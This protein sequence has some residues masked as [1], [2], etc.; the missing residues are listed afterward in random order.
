MSQRN[1]YSHCKTPEELQK[2]YPNMYID[3]EK[4]RKAINNTNTSLCGENHYVFKDKNNCVVGCAKCDEDE[5]QENSPYADM[6]S[7]D[8]TTWKSAQ[9]DA[10]ISGV[11]NN[12]WKNIM[13]VLHTKNK[14]ST[15]EKKNALNMAKQWY[16]NRMDD[17]E[18]INRMNA[19]QWSP[20]GEPKLSENKNLSEVEKE[21]KLK[22]YLK[23][24]KK[25]ISSGRGSTISCVEPNENGEIEVNKDTKLEL[26]ENWSTIKKNIIGPKGDNQLRWDGCDVNKT[27]GPKNI[28]QEEYL[29]WSEEYL[30]NQRSKSNILKDS[31]GAIISDLNA[32]G[33]VT[34]NIMG[35]ELFPISRPFENCINQLLSDYEYG[36]EVDSQMITDIN[37]KNNITELDEKHIEFI[38]RKL[39]LLLISNSRIGV[40]QCMI[41][42]ILK[43]KN[44]CPKNLPQQMMLILNIL[45]S[46]IG[47]NLHLNKLQDNDKQGR[48]KLISIIDKLGD[49]IPRAISKIIDITEEIER[50]SCGMKIISTNTQILKEMN[51]KLFN[52]PKKNIQFNMDIPSVS[53]VIKMTDIDKL[54]NKDEVNDD[55]FQR[56][57]ILGAIAIAVLKFI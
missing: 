36:Y 42:H 29:E 33:K 51:K 20:P 34:S 16:I 28:I 30:R 19:L 45:F 27:F 14:I 15:D 3:I 53:E 21:N 31:S 55:Q 40:K 41:K 9:L 57:T 17:K 50:D 5:K 7:K 11:P 37:S 10:N 23:K 38:K 35:A 44:D 26:G 12:Q 1:I 4:T 47:F 54:F 48:D 52:P 43:D 32:T 13:T 8:E 24:F 25:E 22:E 2:S 6:C 49:L 18:L 56:L 39:E 46:T